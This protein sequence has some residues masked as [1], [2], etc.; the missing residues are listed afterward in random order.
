MRARAARSILL[1]VSV[2]L[3]AGCGDSGK[4]TAEAE[5]WLSGMLKEDAEGGTV[6]AVNCHDETEGRWG[7]LWSS[8]PQAAR[9]STC[10]VNSP[11]I[12]QTVCGARNSA[13]AIVPS[14]ANV[15]RSSSSLLGTL[16]KHPQDRLPDGT[17]SALC[18]TTFASCMFPGRCRLCRP[19]SAQRRR[20]SS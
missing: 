2:L 6:G 13:V 4:S 5:E 3:L 10:Q 18:I 16:L 14:R 1:A 19:R 7:V 17:W 8:R 9:R 15:A 11:A 12:T 20:S